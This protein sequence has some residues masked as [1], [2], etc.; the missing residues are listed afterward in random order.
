MEEM[1]T[2]ANNNHINEAGLAVKGKH[3][4]SV[5]TVL[6]KL[7][8]NGDRSYTGAAGKISNQCASIGSNRGNPTFI[9]HCKYESGNLQNAVFMPS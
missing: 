9:A 5:L 1:A 4:D 3:K 6:R 2:R 7:S 8:L